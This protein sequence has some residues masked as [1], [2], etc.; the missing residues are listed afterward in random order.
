[1]KGGDNPGW[2]L[3]YRFSKVYGYRALTATNLEALAAAIRADPNIRQVFAG[4]YA[5]SA[6]SPI[7]LKNWHFYTCAETHFTTTD[8]GSCMSGTQTGP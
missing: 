5:V 3:E 8:Y 4:Y 1:V 6:R 7:G 2:A